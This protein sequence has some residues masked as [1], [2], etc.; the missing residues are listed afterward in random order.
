MCIVFFFTKSLYLIKKKVKKEKTKGCGFVCF[1]L[2]I[3]KNTHI[4]YVFVFKTLKVK[5]PSCSDL[6]CI[7]LV[8]FHIFSV[9][10]LIFLLTGMEG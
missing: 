8:A 1:L 4:S 10:T 2:F 7:S 3:L 9:L 6:I 5:N